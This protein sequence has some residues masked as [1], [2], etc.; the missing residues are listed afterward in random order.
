MK[1][2]A[3]SA[4]G[5]DFCNRLCI[6]VHVKNEHEWN[7]GT[8]ESVGDQGF[9]PL[10]SGGRLLFTIRRRQQVDS[11]AAKNDE[12][13]LLNKPRDDGAKARVSGAAVA[14]KTIFAG[15]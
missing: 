7:T 15:E 4:A 5:F 9:D 10:R 13:A 12:A 6:R 8:R 3:R 11:Q 1:R 14:L 2:P